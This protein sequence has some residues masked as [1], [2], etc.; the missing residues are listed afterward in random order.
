MIFAEWELVDVYF[1][2]SLR[3]AHRSNFILSHVHKTCDSSLFHRTSDIVRGP[4]VPGSFRISCQWLWLDY[5]SGTGSDWIYTFRK[6]PYKYF[7]FRILLCIFHIFSSFLFYVSLNL[8]S[9]ISMIS[10]HRRWTWL[11]RPDE[12]EVTWSL[13]AKEICHKIVIDHEIYGRKRKFLFAIVQPVP[14]AENL[15]KQALWFRTHPCHPFAQE[16]QGQQRQ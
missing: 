7:L 15:H 11:E 6:H 10:R 8:I 5:F 16:S 13:L 12:A 1:W 14:V 3:A 4:Y 9:I 2:Y